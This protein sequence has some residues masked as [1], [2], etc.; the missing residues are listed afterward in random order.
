MMPNDSWE[1][2]EEIRTEKSNDTVFDTMTFEDLN[3]G[4]FDA[5]YIDDCPIDC[6]DMGIFSWGD[7]TE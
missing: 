5:T 4:I 7:D 1:T 2:E 6:S 3:G